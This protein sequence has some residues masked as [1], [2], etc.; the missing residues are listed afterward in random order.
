[1]E[2]QQ[3]QRLR[4]GA[5]RLNRFRWTSKLA[6][7]RH[8]RPGGTAGTLDKIGHVLLAPELGD[9]SFDITDH[10]GMATFLAAAL[11]VPTAD[12]FGAIE[13]AGSD[14]RLRADYARLKRLSLV[15]RRMRL[16]QRSLWWAIVRLRKPALVVETGVWYGLGSAVILRALELNA[17]EGH[18]GRL[19]SF[20]PDETGG[21]LVPHR[22]HSRW[23][24]VR[25]ST[26]D[27]LEA[28]LFGR[29]LD[30]FIHDTP[31]DYARERYEL[32][33]ALR[34]SAPGAVLLS[35]NGR[36]TPALEEICAAEGLPYHHLPYVA[37]RHF[38]VT[39]GLSLTQ[40][41]DF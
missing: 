27:A 2:V 15:P 38:Y 30:L 8:A 6:N 12:A 34:H 3:R 9:H 4:A 23:Q 41:L 10:V 21:W 7:V 11:S 32:Q 39:R 1:V 24:W 19:I 14:D 40:T 22:L 35:S 36:N 25:A 31:S 26:D 29:E 16:S 17:E 33:V 20:D 37:D 5:R 28:T 18:E 13:E